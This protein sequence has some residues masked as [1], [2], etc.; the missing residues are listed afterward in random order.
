MCCIG[1]RIR[2]FVHQASNSTCVALVVHHAS[3][4]SFVQG[5]N[6]SLA[7]CLNVSSVELSNSSFLACL[8]ASGVWLLYQMGAFM[9]KPISVAKLQVDVANLEL[10]TGCTSRALYADATPGEAFCKASSSFPHA[11]RKRPVSN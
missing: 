9:I 10:S 3:N 8:R 1:H 4:S 6:S 5:S 11:A 2:H 7:A